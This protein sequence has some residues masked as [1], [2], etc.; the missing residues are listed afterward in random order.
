MIR[1]KA[2]TER[3]PQGGELLAERAAREIGERVGIRG[4]AHEGI[5]DRAPR[6]PEDVS[7]DRGQLDVGVFQNFVKAIDGPRAFLHDRLAV[8]REIAELAHR[9]R[10]HGA[11]PQQPVL[12]QLRDPCIILHVGL[13]PR[14]LPHVDQHAGQHLRGAMELT[15]AVG[16]CRCAAPACGRRSP[17]KRRCLGDGASLPRSPDRPVTLSRTS[18]ERH[19][20]FPQLRPWTRRVT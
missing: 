8:A 10:R 14:H 7:R 1:A 15:S 3:L 2:P 6:H 9:H 18:A 4:P 20:H 17:G 5:K 11:A 12:Q 19:P 13:P 16:V